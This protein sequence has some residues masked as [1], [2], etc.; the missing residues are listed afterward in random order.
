MTPHRPLAH[1]LVLDT[2]ECNPRIRI[3]PDIPPHPESN[4]GIVLEHCKLI[5]G[6]KVQ[7]TK[8]GKEVCTLGWIAKALEY[9]Y[10]WSSDVL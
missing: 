1:Y 8:R 4:E 7:R 9:S 3:N 10:N 5:K 2:P 6:G